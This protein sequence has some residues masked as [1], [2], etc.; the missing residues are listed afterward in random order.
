LGVAVPLALVL[1]AGMSFA[2]ARAF[3]PRS[4]PLLVAPVA[5]AT[6]QELQGPGLP[7]LQFVAF[8]REETAPSFESQSSLNVV[9]GKLGRGGNLG[10]TLGR[11]GVPALQVQEITRALRGLLDVRSVQP[12]DFYALI[13]DEQGAVLSFELQRG[14]QKVYRLERAEDGSLQASEEVLP[15]ERRV[16]QVGGVVD[17]S[18]FAS[19]LALGEGAE[20]VQ[21]F[22]DIFAYEF[23]FSTQTRPG[24]EFRIVFE[25]HYDRNGFVG[26]GNVLAAQYRTPE[27]ELVG[28]RF[29]DEHSSGA[30]Y[31]TPDGKS[32]RKAF[33][34]A[35]VNYTR[36]SSGFSY[37]RLHPIFKQ[38][39]K[40]EGIDYAAP[41]GTPV[42]SIG[43][44]V[45]VFQGWSGGFGRLVKVKHANGYVSY[46]GHLSRFSKGLRVGSRVTQKQVVG[47]VGMTGWATGPHLDFRLE[48]GGRFVNPLNVSFP[49]G[50]PIR[51]EDRERFQNVRDELL[52]ELRSADPAIVLEAGM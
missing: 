3:G 16:T 6:P 26:Y 7:E 44:G 23:D 51:T 49:H 15:L 45:V 18:L 25:K 12:D 32:L 42:W 52:A 30:A 38:R 37:A 22:S 2:V 5:V 41:T 27:R 33:L 24:D 40:H 21:A 1:C 20:L 17:R 11:H 34:K 50:E 36:I 29:E 10:S 28:L 19:V 43:D 4:A 46:Y 48:R 9:T 14:R 47:Y 8:E 35:P 31:Y 39:R 13:R